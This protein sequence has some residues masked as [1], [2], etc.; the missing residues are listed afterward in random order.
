VLAL[1]VLLLLLLQV[2]RQRAWL[3]V[4]QLHLACQALQSWCP[5]Q[6]VCRK[7]DRW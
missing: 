2:L 4:A 1:H 5:H 3:R 6:P 7:S